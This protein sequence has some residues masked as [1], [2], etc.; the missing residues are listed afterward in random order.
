VQCHQFQI[1]GTGTD[2]PDDEYLVAI[3]GAYKAEDPG[4][5]INI[6]PAPYASAYIIRELSRG[7]ASIF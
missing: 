4:L 6:D 3:P 7:R 2:F 5:L 1:T